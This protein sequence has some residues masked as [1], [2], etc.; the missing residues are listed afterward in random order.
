M[1]AFQGLNHL[2]L[3]RLFKRMTRQEFK[4]GEVIFYSI[5]VYS[6]LYFILSGKVMLS[7]R[8]EEQENNP[9]QNTEMFHLQ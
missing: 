5:D 6:S 3:L 2:D 4:E 8:P 9:D 1:K 7:F